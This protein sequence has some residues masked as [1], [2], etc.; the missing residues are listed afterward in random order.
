MVE[1]RGDDVYLRHLGVD[2]AAG[3]LAL[4]LRNREFFARFEP[5]HP[6]PVTTLDEQM[7]AILRDLDDARGDR[8]YY[9]GIFLNATGELIGR[10]GLFN[11]VREAFQ[12]AVCGYFLD[13]SKNNLGY[14]SQAVQ[15]LVRYAFDELGLHRVEA[16]V[17]P[18]N[19]GSIRVLEKA[20]FRREGL[21]ENYLQIN[22]NWEDHYGFAITAEDYAAFKTARA[23]GATTSKP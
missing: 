14:M 22:G 7:A 12:N 1:L 10:I 4:R 15:L 11:I 2:D 13:E 8:T 19:T 3:L 17:M 20:G 5:R 23:A 9:F 16:G 18:R 6:R 21:M